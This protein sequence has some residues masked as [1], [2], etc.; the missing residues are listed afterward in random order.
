MLLFSNDYPRAHFDAYNR[1]LSTFYI[2]ETIKQA[3]RIE[4]LADKYE[5][6]RKTFFDEINDLK[7]SYR[8]R[9]NTKRNELEEFE[10]LKKQ[11][12]QAAAQAEE[13]KRKREAEESARIIREN[14]VREAEQRKQSELNA[15]Q[16]QMQDMFNASDQTVTY[17][18]PKVKVKQKIKVVHAAGMVE[19]YNFW[20]MNEGSSLPLDELEKIHKKMITFA[21]KQANSSDNI[22]INS[23]YLQ[24]E[25]DVKAK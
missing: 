3:I 24:Y 13:E 15:Q 14:Q 16:A 6:L 11:N 18:P 5:S 1:S 12:A 19:L 4:V 2:D 7:Q 21:E 23:K 22:L 9:F 25:E 8:I 20:W 17:T 10:I